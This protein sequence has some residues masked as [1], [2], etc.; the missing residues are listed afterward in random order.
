MNGLI[1]KVLCCG[2]REGI[3]V[4]GENALPRFDRDGY[5]QIIL[6]ARPNGINRDGKPRMFGFTYLRLSDRL[7]SEP[8]FT[9]FKTFVKRMHANQVSNQKVFLRTVFGSR[10][11]LAFLKLCFTSW[12]RNIVQSLKGTVTSYFHWKDRKLMNHWRS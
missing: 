6:N 4:A 11:S 10:F 5:N 3:E 9:T 12:F 7:L 8:N 2:W 1:F